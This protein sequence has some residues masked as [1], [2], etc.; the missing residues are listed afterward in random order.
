MDALR[1]ALA[2]NEAELATTLARRRTLAVEREKLQL[3]LAL[4]EKVC[5]CRET[6]LQIKQLIEQEEAAEAAAEAAAHAAV[7]AETALDSMLP[8]TING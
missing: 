2:D 5:V 6:R 4:C 8:D 3:Q 1:Q 7:E